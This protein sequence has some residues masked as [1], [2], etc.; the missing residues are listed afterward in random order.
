MSLM[1]KLFNTTDTFARGNALGGQLAQQE[2]DS[3]IRGY[4]SKI[5]QQ[6]QSGRFN[7][8]NNMELQ[9]I[10]AI[11]PSRAQKMINTF[12]EL[13]DSRKKAYFED[14]RKARRYLEAGDGEG[15]LNLMSDRLDAVEELKG[16]PSGVQ[17]VISKYLSGNTGEV[18]NGIRNAEK[19]GIEQGLIGAADDIMPSIAKKEKQM[20]GTPRNV[21]GGS[22]VTY[23]DGSQEFVPLPA[24]A[25]T[26]QEETRQRNLPT[27]NASMQNKQ[28]QFQESANNAYS[29]AEK[30]S[31]LADNFAKIDAASGVAGSAR[32][33]FLKAIGGQ[34]EISNLR[35]DFTRIRNKLITANLPQGP[36]TDKDIELIAAGFPEAT[37]S[38]AQIVDFLRAMSRGQEAIAKFDEFKSVFLQENGN[39]TRATR[40]FEFDGQKV[41]KGERLASAYKRISKDLQPRA[42]QATPTGETLSDEDMLK[43]YGGL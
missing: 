2:K 1:S 39:I 18:I 28:I 17:M 14:M 23:S 12:S 11:D 3:E 9:Q 8:E 38:Q 36:A 34:D 37:A 32:E 19:L 21:E 20:Q 15:F 22:I 13:S 5:Q 16:D 42:E 7:P 30:T 43:K 4:Q 33:S 6:M 35:K 40:D 26:A 24:E 29:L 27:L 31:A 41:K 25:I 10:A